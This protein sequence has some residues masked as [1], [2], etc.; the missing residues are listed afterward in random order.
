MPDVSSYSLLFSLLWFNAQQ[1]QLRSSRL[2]LKAKRTCGFGIRK[3]IWCGLRFFGVSLWGFA[4]FGPPLRP[5]P[6]V[7]RGSPSLLK[8]SK[9]CQRRSYRE[10]AYP[11]G[12]TLV[13][14][15]SAIVRSQCFSHQKS[16]IAR[17]VL[18]FIQ[19]TH[20]FRSLH[21]S[22][23]TNYWKLCQAR[24]Q[25]LT[26]F[27]QRNW[28]PWEIGPQAWDRSFQPAGVRVAKISVTSPNIPT[29]ELLAGER[30]L[31]FIVFNI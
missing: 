27:N 31:L 20:G 28:P 17:K 21:G 24:Q 10:N 4:V 12:P 22:E 14:N 7:F 1:W 5:P 30:V 8:T 13:D 9:V 19:F 18:S 23:L 15:I 26:F 6:E 25:Q 11:Q 16:E 29:R 3:K 2:Q